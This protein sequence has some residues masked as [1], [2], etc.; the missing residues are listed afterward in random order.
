MPKTATRINGRVALAKL[1]LKLQMEIEDKS[2]V[3]A[4]EIGSRT[5]SNGTNKSQFRPIQ[6]NH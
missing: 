3:G 1:F 6:S 2:R 5:I 4:G